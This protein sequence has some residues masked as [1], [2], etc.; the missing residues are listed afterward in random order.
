VKPPVAFFCRFPEKLP[1][2]STMPSVL[3]H[4]ET[5]DGGVYPVAGRRC[6]IGRSPDCDVRLPSPE[7]SRRHAMILWHEKEVWLVDT[8]SSGGTW[9][10]DEK[11]SRA[12]KLESGDL[13]GFGITGLRFI[14]ASI[15]P[16]S[17]R[18]GQLLAE[19]TRPGDA[20]WLTTNDTAVLWVSF[21]GVITGGSKEAVSWMAAFFEGATD[22]LP[23]SVAEWLE[24]G[25][26]GRM[27]FESRVGDQRL[28]ISVFPGGEDRLLLVLRRIEPAFSAASL[29]RIG[30]SRAEAAIVPW[31]IRGKRNDEIAV[32]LGS[33]P[34]TIEKQVASVLSKLDVETR[35][36]AAWN[37]IER[38][39]AHR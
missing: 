2:S 6:L 39:G 8:G 31:L 32:I 9:L 23:A 26:A 13:I 5:P 20:E 14:A 21:D 15:L 10:N 11:I 24:G 22:S 4:L 1:H 37:I 17:G 38:T 16:G 29:G 19:T 12:A 33:A 18:P 34:K 25:I 35:T 28:R 36:A 30:L 3:F 27:P 7:V